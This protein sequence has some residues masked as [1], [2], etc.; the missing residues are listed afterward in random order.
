MLLSGVNSLAPDALR[1]THAEDT[2]TIPVTHLPLATDGEERRL[3]FGGQSL[4]I[5]RR[6]RARSR[7]LQRAGAVLFCLSRR[8]SEIYSR[9]VD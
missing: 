9:A 1:T 6:N 2:A 5:M 8:S 4:P 7:C 3:N